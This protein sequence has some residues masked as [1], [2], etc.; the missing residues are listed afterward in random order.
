MKTILAGTLL[1]LTAAAS[2]E[3][4]YVAPGGKDTNPGTRRRPLATLTGARDAARAMKAG[5][6]LAGPL[7]III[8]GGTY[9]IT[10]PLELSAEDS[11][12]A[13]APIV[14]QAAAGARPVF[15]GGRVLTGWK[16]VEPGLWTTQVPEVASGQWYFEQLFV[17]GRRAIR[18]RSPNKFYYYIREIRETALENS[19]SPDRPKRAQQTL[20]MQ[21]R[22]FLQ[23]L[24]QTGAAEVRDI[25][26]VVYHNWDSTRRFLDRADPQRAELVTSGLPMPSWNPWRTNSLFHLENYLGALD[27]PGEWFLARNGT[28]YYRSL[29]GEDPRK[30]SVVAPVAERFLAIRGDAAAG[31]YV[32]HVA[33]RGLTFLHGQWL[34]PPGGFEAAQAAAPIEAV[35]MADGA[36]D[37]MIEDCEIGHVGTYAVWFRKG[38]H[39]CVL[40]HSY[41][42]DFGAG[43]V[44]VGET[45]IAPKEA[46]R[47]SRITV[48]NNIIRD[49]GSVFPCAVGVWIG[50]SPENAVMHNEIADLYY[51]GISV[52]WRWGYGESLAKRNTIT[53][54]RVHH[55]G[56]GLL[57]DMGGIYTLGPSEGTAVRNNVF[58]D[59]YSCSYGGWGMY[60]DEGSTGILFENNLVYRVKT[61]GFHQHYGRDN[62]IRNNIMSFS[63]VHQLQATRPEDHLSFTLERNIVYWDSGA[64]LGGAWNSVQYASRGNCY[65]RTDGKPVDFLGNS[66][67]AWQ[68]KGREQGSLVADPGFADAARGDYQIA[69][70]SPALALGF[71][72]FDYRAAGVRGDPAWI[73]LANDVSYPPLEIIPAPPPLSPD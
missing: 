67:E 22:A 61:G 9:R 45:T 28:L 8:A 57:S 70:G 71:K 21:S 62:M 39:D 20:R 12:T 43:G 4:L 2:A 18:A 27:A 46:D 72:P 38:C 59:I 35:V 51:T 69:P 31:K 23:A 52:G 33:F 17:G 54:N 11:G 32:E 56:W 6:A 53:S 47:T 1:L 55:I 16:E 65:W 37:V 60:T 73:A 5:G 3:D 24:G 25:N 50:H 10:G 42:H 30:A 66:L 68:A 36:R 64:L 44:R 41:L 26:L 29:P 34:M 7:R 49:G 63:Q 19:A 15:T 40:R 48:D 14:Y 58:H 13:Q